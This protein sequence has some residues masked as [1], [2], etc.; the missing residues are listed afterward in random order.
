[1]G[2]LPGARLGA[3]RPVEPARPLHLARLHGRDDPAADLVHLSRNPRQ[4][5][6]R[7][8]VRSPKR[9]QA[10]LDHTGRRPGSPSR[11]NGCATP[12]PSWRQALNAAQMERFLTA[13][14]TY[15]QIIASL[16]APPEKGWPEGY[17]STLAEALNNLAWLL[18]D[19]PRNRAARAE[20]SRRMRAP[21]RRDRAPQRDASGTRSAWRITE[22]ATGRV[23]TRPFIGRSNGAAMVT[24][25]I[26]SFWRSS[27]TSAVE[28]TR[29]APGMTRPSPGPSEQRPAQQGAIPLPARSR[30]GARSA[31]SG[32]P[33]ALTG[34]RLIRSEC[35]RSTN[36]GACS[37]SSRS[38]SSR[39][40]EPSASSR[41]RS[42]RL[43]TSR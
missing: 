15:D 14:D 28:K 26:G 37:V 7:A 4:F 2:R 22:P 34:P 17:E 18:V 33:P 25:S 9:C 3:P 21:R 16:D 30:R 29:P 35:S 40:S 6:A 24:V 43:Q 42:A 11:S 39:R 19:L 36:V 12:A 1:M 31:R 13:K 41:A 10:E 38:P 32:A 27:T 20:A 8:P 23:P 5:A